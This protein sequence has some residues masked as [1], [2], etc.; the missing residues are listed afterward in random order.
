M[1][2]FQSLIYICR[3]VRL[4]LDQKN[5]IFWEGMGQP[6]NVD[7]TPGRTAQL[8]YFAGKAKY[9]LTDY[10]YIRT[11]NRIRIQ[12]NPEDIID[13]N[14]I[15]FR[16]Q[17]FGTHWYFGFI[18]NTHYINDNTTEIEWKLD[19]IQTWA[20]D[21][22]LQP[23]YIERGHVTRDGVGQNIVPE[24][25][26]VGNYVFEEDNITERFGANQPNTI[27]IAR[28]TDKDFQPV[29]GKLISGIYQGCEFLAQADALA[30][31]R[32]IE[33]MTE[34]N[35]GDSIVCIFMFPDSM[36]DVLEFNERKI[37]TIPANYA[38]ING[39]SPKNNKLFTYPYN[40]LTITDNEGNTGNLRYENFLNPA[41]GCQF[42]YS[43]SLTCNPQLS[44]YPIRYNGQMFNVS[45]GITILFPM[46]SYNIDTYKA[47][48][49]QTH[50]QRTTNEKV[51]T[52]TY[53]R[54]TTLNT[55]GTIGTAIGNVALGNIP[56]AVATVA[57]GVLGQMNRDI[58]YDNEIAKINAVEDDRS[59]QPPQS[60]GT[61]H[62]DVLWSDQLKGVRIYPTTIRAENA[63]IIDDYWTMFGYPIHQI[64]VPNLKARETWTYI[65]T[66]GVNMN[67]VIENKYLVELKN[68]FELGLTFWNNGDE[69]GEYGRSNSITGSWTY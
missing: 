52:S 11:S 4:D 37:I 2:P 13:C 33:D 19:V 59:T 29:Q 54:Q 65:K 34:N 15:A 17:S 36:L 51:V 66:K 39:Y 43:A 49:A 7:K 35:A 30:A 41:G 23:S 55:I 21:F 60:Q 57:G 62:S 1:R 46:C 69:I 42:A 18:T 63:R 32:T 31:S 25:L 27:Y 12:L 10:S 9:T 22:E 16:N 50:Y 44:L 45:E 47:W 68:Y 58:S 40:F 38:T 53:N 48:L 20:F 26:P 5:S 28:T 61:T 56:G 24:N 8:A 14:Y 67:T 6:V 3:Q 64:H